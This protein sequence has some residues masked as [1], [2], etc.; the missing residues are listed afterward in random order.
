MDPTHARNY[1]RKAFVGASDGRFT[2]QDFDEWFPGSPGHGEREDMLLEAFDQMIE[3]ANGSALS[4]P[5]RGR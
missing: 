3:A 4:S 5:T 2:E 1:W